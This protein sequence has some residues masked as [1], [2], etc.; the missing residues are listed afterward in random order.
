MNRLS[1]VSWIP[2]ILLVASVPLFLIAASVTYAF[3]DAGLYNR[4]FQRYNVS[5]ATGITGPDLVQAGAEFRRYFNSRREPLSVRARVYGLEQELFNPRE[6]HHMG[7][8]KRRIWGV[9]AVGGI[10]GVY[11]FA[12]TVAG[13][14]W[15]PRMCAPWL[16]RFYL[17]GGILTLALILAVGLFSV[18]N[19]DTLFLKFHQITFTN[20]LW[21]GNPNTDYLL[22][23]FPQGFWF[24]STALVASIIIIGSVVTSV[25]SGGYLMWRRR[26]RDEVISHQ[27]TGT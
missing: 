12:L 7:D 24:D 19:F 15:R 25:V 4:G 9:Y 18:V 6:I 21:M 17:R 2:G 14:V 27:P 10:T 26:G 11:L 1:R 3:N 16:A 22:K 20:D 8:V 5:T 13:L 23:M